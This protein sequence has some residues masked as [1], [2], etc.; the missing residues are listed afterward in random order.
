MTTIG[1][2]RRHFGTCSAR[3]AGPGDRAPG[4]SA[5]RQVTCPG[6]AG[7]AG[8][9]ACTGCRAA[10]P[11]AATACGRW[12]STPIR[13]SGWRCVASR[14]V[15][16]EVLELLVTDPD[17]LVADRADRIAAFR[18]DVAGTSAPTRRLA[19]GSR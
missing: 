10:R 7:C 5:T 17:P 4:A 13:G 18:G 19:T 14:R 1:L 15:P 16:A 11:V 9:R 6:R 12:R 2:C 8:G 3:G